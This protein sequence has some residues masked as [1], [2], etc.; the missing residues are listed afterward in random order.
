MIL[1][2]DGSPRAAVVISDGAP[3]AERHAADELAAFLGEVT[4]A[5]SGR[6]P[7]R[8]PASHWMEVD[9]PIASLPPIPDAHAV[10]EA[11][12]ESRRPVPG[13][14]GTADSAPCTSPVAV[15]PLLAD[16]APL[17]ELRFAVAG[18][19]LAVLADVKDPRVTRRDVPW[20]GSCVQV[21]AAM[22]G[23]SPEPTGVAGNFFPVAEVD[24][25]PGVGTNPPAAW[26]VLQ[27]DPRRVPA[28]DVRIAGASSPDGYRLSALIPLA[29]LGLDGEAPELRLEFQLTVGTK[30]GKR[31]TGNVFGSERAYRDSVR[32]GR[33]KQ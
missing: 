22:P 26:C 2:A 21:F 7:G 11:L 16:G 15:F 17:A 27:T 4:V 25:L 18:S 6:P 24:L 23:R 13:G 1:A 31:E 12:A 9:H 30:D 19:N 5:R 28:S 32:Y 8:K 3:E 20:E 10:A 14:R 29:R 33:M